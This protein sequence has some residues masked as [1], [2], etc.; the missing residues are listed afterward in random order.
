MDLK[1]KVCRGRSARTELVREAKSY[2]SAK[3][4]LGVSKTE[5]RAQPSAS[6]AK[7]CAKRLSKS[8]SV[9]A[10]DNGK[11]VFQKNVTKASIA[12]GAVLLFKISPLIFP[13]L[14]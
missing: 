3:L 9:F 2:P 6:L 5:H 14:R 11:I 4:I 12:E 10:V 7:S 8:F 13:S 1:L